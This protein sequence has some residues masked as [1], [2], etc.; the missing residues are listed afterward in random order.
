MKFTKLIVGAVVGG[1]I[2]VGA[3]QVHRSLLL[4]QSGQ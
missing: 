4:L 2:T 1:A 3:V